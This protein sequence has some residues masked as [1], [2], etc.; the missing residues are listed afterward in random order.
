MK[1]IL[2][3]TAIMALA[4]AATASPAA[5]KKIALLDSENTRAFFAAHYPGCGDDILNPNGAHSTS[6]YLGKT[7]SGDEYQRYFRGWQWVL[8]NNGYDYTVI[9]DDDVTAAGLEPYDLLIL[10]ND[11]LLSD[12]QTRAVQKWVI[13][14][15]SLLATFGASYK[16]LGSDPRQIDGWKEQKG[17]TF[18]LH[19]LWHDPMEK[20]FSTLWIDPGVDVKITRYEGPTADLKGKLAGDIL[21]YGAEANLLV[22]RPLNFPD[23]Y[24]F[25]VIDNPDWKSTTPAIISTGFGK[26]SVIYFAF[27]PE[28]IVYKELEH[29]SHP[30]GNMPDGWQ[31]CWDQQD[32]R[33]RSTDL[34]VLM[35][36]AI[37]YLLGK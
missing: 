24:A 34:R 36:S 11:A 3:L 27:A 8:A 20:L 15:G 7:G 32:W 18:G 10:S 2:M 4:L 25:L 37:K 21:G 19:Q 13:G 30:L 12:D 1:R 17:G 14:G 28:Y 29:P 6:Y 33:G 23:V 35:V 5:P 9:H 26:G 22:G 31:G 16:N